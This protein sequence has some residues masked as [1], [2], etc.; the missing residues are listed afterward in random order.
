MERKIL[1][2]INSK[3]EYNVPHLSEYSKDT[4]RNILDGLDPLIP[5]YD[6]SIRHH[7]LLLMSLSKILNKAQFDQI[8][9]T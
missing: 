8:K 3:I 1:K 2:N 9:I 6:S 7:K 5:N 4:I